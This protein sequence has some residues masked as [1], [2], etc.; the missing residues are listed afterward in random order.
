MVTYLLERASVAEHLMRRRVA[1]VIVLVVACG[2]LVATT[3]S[4]I[5]STLS[6]S[7]SGS[8]ALTFEAP[9][10]TGL[11]ELDL[12]AAV[13]PE[14]DDDS[15]LRIRGTVR[16]EQRGAAHEAVV[17]HVRPVGIDAASHEEYGAIVWPIEHLCRVAEPCQREF[18]VALEW[19]NPEPG[20]AQQGSFQAIVEVVYEEM[21]ENPEG[22]TADWSESAPFA[23]AP[24]GPSVSAATE[25]ERVTLNRD[26]PVVI[27]HAALTA[28]EIARS[29]RTAVFVDSSVTQ[30]RPDSVRVILL[31]DAPTGED[32]TASGR[33]IDPFVDCS[34]GLCERGVT[35]LIE[36]A[37]GDPNTTA[38]VEWSL[39]AHA[40]FADESE[41]PDGAELSAVVDRAV[42]F[43]SETPVLT[44]MSSGRLEPGPDESG[45]LRSFSKV[46][47]E[48]NRASL[49]SG[50]APGV[51]PL[52][53][54]ILS[55]EASDDV[56]VDVMVPGRDQPTDV[57]RT[58]KLGRTSTAARTDASILVYPLHSCEV[59]NE[60][61]VG[62]TLSAT[63][64]TPAAAD[65]D[66]AVTV[67]WSLSLEVLYPGLD[68]P[69]IGADVV[70]DVFIDDR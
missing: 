18:E 68:A 38:V 15:R 40:T 31:P 19:V 12:S 37:D 2:A 50:V 67:E 17:L 44:T 51:P 36:L 47:I 46:V 56:T 22:A 29:G 59:D 1:A 43:D 63:T 66:R 45:T 49:S 5:Q 41:V 57:Y 9:R 65:A 21:E 14:I 26:Q 42:D 11:V 62:I 23:S 6:A 53:I 30:S 35:I 60:C 10:A 28:S 8:A 16:F 7:Y 69:P 13:L 25:P 20:G 61:A 3:P 27:R 32:E 4:Q 52:A 39:Q 55:F 24:I 33:A 54:G 64:V 58:L 34:A 48:A 70:I